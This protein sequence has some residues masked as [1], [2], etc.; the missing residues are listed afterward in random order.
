MAVGVAGFLFIINANANQISAIVVSI[1]CINLFLW[2]LKLDIFKFELRSWLLRNSCIYTSPHHEITLIFGFFGLWYVQLSLI[3]S[4]MLTSAVPAFGQIISY[5]PSEGSGISYGINIPQRTAANGT[6]PIFFQMTA[7]ADIKWIALG[8]GPRM[9]DGNLFIVYAAPGGNVTLSPRKAKDHIEPEY[10][11]DVQATLLDGSGFHNGNI[12]ANIQCDNCMHLRDGRPIVAPHSDWIW[13]M[14]HGHPIMSSNVSHPI[15]QHDWHGIFTLDLTEGVGG[16]TENPFLLS[17]HTVIDH[18][19][20]SKQQQISDAILRKKRIGHGVMT[21]IAFV[22]L[23]PNFA[24]TLYIVPSRWT[25]AWIHAPL[26]IFAVGLALAGYAVGISVGHDLQEGGGYHPIL[27]HIAIIGVVVFQPVL[28]IMQ[29]LRYRK[30]GIKTLWGHAHRWLGRFLSV[31]GVVN[32]GL[33]FHYALGKNPDI[34]PVSSI[35]YAIICAFMGM[36][37][38][39]IVVWRKYHS[40]PLIIKTDTEDGL[41]EPGPEPEITSKLESKTAR[42]QETPVEGSNASS[43]SDVSVSKEKPG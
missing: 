43:T 13:A 7:P 8:Q 4:L 30:F 24:L 36:L 42:V 23:F 6:G 20:R 19:L 35:A 27:G 3:Q 12:T 2:L 37:Y 40:K 39:S 11:P 41:H 1:P 21:S 38:I 28:G 10:N 16:E 34:P 29:H 31:L 15:S 5:T 18:T 33:G 25:V 9:I 22:L 32:G 14:T 26:Q 17:S